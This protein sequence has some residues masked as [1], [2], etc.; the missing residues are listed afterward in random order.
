MLLKQLT[1]GHTQIAGR[2]PPATQPQLLTGAGMQPDT[3]AGCLVSTHPLSQQR[4]QQTAEH[5][6]KTCPGHGRMPP[7]TQ[8]QAT[9][10][11]GHQTASPLEHHHGAI[12]TGQLTR[13]GWPIILHLTDRATQQAGGL[14]GMR[15]QDALFGQR[16]RFQCQQIE[17]IGIQHPGASLLQRPGWA[18]LPAVREDRLC[19][20][21]PEQADIAVRAGPRMAEGARLMAQCLNRAAGA[22]R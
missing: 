15:G 16:L 10:R 22:G 11:G 1:N 5:I 6:A 20:F 9:I 12:T 19:V 3:E 8:R 13:S 14:T 4:P 18:Q 7:L 17:R 21:A 2:Q